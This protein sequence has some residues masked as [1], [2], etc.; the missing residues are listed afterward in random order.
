MCWVDSATVN[1]QSIILCIEFTSLFTGSLFMEQRSKR[2]SGEKDFHEENSNG[3]PWEKSSVSPPRRLFHNHFSSIYRRT[4]QLPGANHFLAQNLKERSSSSA[5]PIE[6]IQHIG[7]RQNIRLSFPAGQ[8]DIRLRLQNL[9]TRT[10]ESSR[11]IRCSIRC[12]L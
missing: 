4:R 6:T 5:A 1:W 2:K 3:N 9:F 12:M 7:D 8:T 11:N 10:D